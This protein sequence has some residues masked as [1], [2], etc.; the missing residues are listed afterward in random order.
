MYINYYK[1]HADTSKVKHWQEMSASGTNNLRVYL[2]FCSFI[3]F[4]FFCGNFYLLAPDRIFPNFFYLK[5]VCDSGMLVVCLADIGSSACSFTH[6]GRRWAGFPAVSR[7][8]VCRQFQ[9]A[10]NYGNIREEDYVAWSSWAGSAPCPA[11]D[12]M[13]LRMS[14]H[15][16]KLHLMWYILWYLMIGWF[17]LLL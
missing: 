8:K 10:A 14:H 16:T 17:S 2:Y 5:R 4:Q 15:I 1:I 9:E 7:W 3:C 12:I 6:D 11:T 13:N